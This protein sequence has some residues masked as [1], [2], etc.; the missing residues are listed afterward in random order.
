MAYYINWDTEHLKK[1]SDEL[2][3][4]SNT[5]EQITYLIDTV[6]IGTLGSEADIDFWEQ[7]RDYTLDQINGTNVY[8]AN[9]KVLQDRQEESIKKAAQTIG[10]DLIEV[11]PSKG[12]IDDSDLE[13][14]PDESISLPTAS[15]AYTF[16]TEVHKSI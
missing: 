1:K 11:K 5:T 2:L 10:L 4:I 8:S 15:E 3:S 12:I 14:P 9:L 7:I 13:S 16:S 6:I